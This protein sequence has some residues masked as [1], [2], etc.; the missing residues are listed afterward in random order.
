[1]FSRLGA[2]ERHCHSLLVRKQV[3]QSLRYC[4]KHKVVGLPPK[5]EG[6]LSASS[7]AVLS[8]SEPLTLPAP[9]GQV[10]LDAAVEL[11]DPMVFTAVYRFCH[12]RLALALP[13]LHPLQSSLFPVN[14]PSA[15]KSNHTWQQSCPR[16]AQ[17]VLGGRRPG[18]GQCPLYG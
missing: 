18:A 15:I 12:V 6:P 2:H 11:G 17:P 10:F 13:I 1:M 8:S 14:Q 3:L 7:P 4:Q 9:H 5:V 16:T